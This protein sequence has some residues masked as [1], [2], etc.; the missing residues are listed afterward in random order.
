MAN[1]LQVDGLARIPGYD[2][3][4]T[5]RILSHLIASP[6]ALYDVLVL[7]GGRIKIMKDLV[8]RDRELPAN[9][10]KR[11]HTCTYTQKYNS[12]LNKAEGLGI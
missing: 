11:I 9:T 1:T 7:N 2:T 12:K 5:C 8:D 4:H 6:H 10:V 3:Y